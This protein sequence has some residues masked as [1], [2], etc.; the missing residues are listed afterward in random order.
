MLILFGGGGHV[1]RAGPADASMADLMVW[2]LVLARWRDFRAR[3]THHPCG[4]ELAWRPWASRKRLPHL[5]YCAEL[6]WR[7]RASRPWL[8][9][10]SRSIELAR[11][12][13]TS[14]T[15]HH[16]GNSALLCHRVVPLGGHDARAG[17]VGSRSS[18]GD[19]RM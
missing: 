17:E 6:G 16:S 8:P 5:A 12:L 9:Y 13:R 15:G 1:P 4:I 19:G 10:H 11:G 14:R 3:L 7:P 18:C 2:P